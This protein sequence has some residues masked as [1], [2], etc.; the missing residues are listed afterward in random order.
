VRLFPPLG[1]LLEGLGEGAEDYVGA[2]VAE[3]LDGLFGVV[4][5]VPE[6][7][8][9]AVGGEVRADALTDGAGVREGKGRQGR[10]EDNGFGLFGE[11]V[12][13]LVGE[14]VGGEQEGG[15]VSLLH[16][17]GE[18]KG[19]ELVGLIAGGDADYS[20]LFGGG[21]LSHWGA[22]GFVGGDVDAGALIGGCVVARGSVGRAV[23]AG[24]SIGRRGIA[25]GLVGEGVVAGGWIFECDFVGGWIG[26]GVV[27][28]VGGGMIVREGVRGGEADGKIIA[29]EDVAGNVLDVIFG[30][31]I[32]ELGDQF[33]D[34]EEEEVGTG[35][36]EGSLVAVLLGE[37]EGGND[38]GVVEL[39][40]RLAAFEE[41]VGDGVGLGL[42]HGEEALVEVGVGG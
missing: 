40:E 2:A 26:E 16:K 6:A 34:A 22:N 18:H 13:E 27:A 24:G 37:R 30:V 10:D 41:A 35:V 31:V 3:A 20:E 29:G 15:V 19:G 17:L 4:G 23:A 32:G 1:Y 21:G 8:A 9:D 42:I 5:G 38:D 12:E 11:G 36:V 7:D 25:R 33:A 39:D 14:G 28:G